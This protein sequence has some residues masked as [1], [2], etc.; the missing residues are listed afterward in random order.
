MAS[1]GAVEHGAVEPGAVEFQTAKNFEKNKD[2][3]GAWP[4]FLAAAEKGNI[5]AN[6]VVGEAYDDEGRMPTD[7]T[8][9]AEHYR[10]A[11]EGNHSLAMLNLATLYKTG[12][13]V[14][15]NNHEAARLYIRVIQKG[16]CGN[17]TARLMLCLLV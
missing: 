4:Y 13:G 2:F 6:F 8:K 17:I 3:Q 10:R 1:F 9:A 5:E 14:E 7:Y 15:Q 11:A 12:N 16:G